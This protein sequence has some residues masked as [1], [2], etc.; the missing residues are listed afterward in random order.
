MAAR[1]AS[2]P[3][4]CS[5]VDTRWNRPSTSQFTLACRQLTVILRDSDLARLY[6]ENWRTR[7]QHFEAQ[8]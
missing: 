2:G 5:S 3:R 1:R 7:Q 8:V 4:A 6:G